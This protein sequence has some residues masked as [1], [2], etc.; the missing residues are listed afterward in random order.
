MYHALTLCSS[1]FYYLPFSFWMID[2]DKE[3]GLCVRA[4]P[5]HKSWLFPSF[6]SMVYYY[7]PQTKGTL[8]PVFFFTLIIIAII[9]IALELGWRISLSHWRSIWSLLAAWKGVSFGFKP[10]S[11]KY[12]LEGDSL[13]I[14]HIIILRLIFQAFE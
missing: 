11:P 12:S 5:C 4:S 10:N 9:L 3:N 1:C 7:I 2:Q 6:D 14:V 8:C 13:M